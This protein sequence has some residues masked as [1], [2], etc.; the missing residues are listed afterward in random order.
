[1]LPDAEEAPETETAPPEE[2]A[3]PADRE[4][5]EPVVEEAPLPK[6]KAPKKPDLKPSVQAAID[7]LA[8]PDAETKAEPAKPA[9]KAAKPVE[10]AEAKAP[11]KT[12]D[13]DEDALAGFTPD[14][15][16]G[17]RGKTRDRI[18]TLH[19]RAR[20]A[21]TSLAEKD[22]A[23][24]EYEPLAKNFKA[25]DELIEK[26]GVREDLDSTPA[27]E[28]T[29][30][31]ATTAAYARAGASIARGERPSDQDIAKLQGLHQVVGAMLQPLGLARAGVEPFEGKLPDE[32]NDRVATGEISI[33]EARVLAAHAK[34]SSAKPVQLRP[35]A[36]RP[37]QQPA[38]R[39]PAPV[40]A[41]AAKRALDDA[42]VANRQI[43][44]LISEAG[45]DP[46]NVATH[47][48][49]N[50]VPIIDRLVKKELGSDVT[51]ADVPPSMRADYARR[52]QAEFQAKSSNPSAIAPATKPAVQREPSPLAHGNRQTRSSVTK[53][54]S[55]QDEFLSSVIDHMS[56]D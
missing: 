22:K 44:S 4:S 33:A 54:G 8:A 53:G 47:F 16:K 52:A 29:A 20:T 11:E 1:M 10:K 41:S 36:Q 51:Q 45:V 46:K 5:E 2:S 43:A 18:Q 17:L 23:I 24:A 28:F 15:A 9:A 14:E 35:A 40:Q 56:A 30:A 48:R 7:K 42:A 34:A 12:E 49:T 38:Q 6:A 37:Q 21:E 27:E 50:L 13:K 3:P 25:F 31:I 39:Q 19:A 32:L 26:A 55:H